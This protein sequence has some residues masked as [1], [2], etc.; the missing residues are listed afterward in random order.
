MSATGRS[1][2]LPLAILALAA[3]S[4]TLGGRVIEQTPAT[5]P[6]E[7]TTQPGQESR[8]PAAEISNDEGGPVVITGELAYTYPF[9]TEAVAEPIVILEDQ[10]GFVAR[11]RDFV[12]PV[13]SQVLGQI[14]SDFYT[15][16]FTYSLTLPLVPRGTLRDVDQDGGKD[17]GVMVF[18]VAY[19][20]NTWGDP[21]LERRDQGGGGWSSAYAST[22]VSDDRETYLEVYGGQLVIYAGDDQQGFPSGFGA[23]GL[24]FTED[25]PIVQLPQGWTVVNLD[26]EPFTFD[27]SRQP[28]IDLLEPES[29]ALDDFS[30]MSYAEGFDAMLEKFRTEYAFTEYKGLNWDAKSAEFRPRFEAAEA[31]GD[32]QAYWLALRD[33]LWSIPD[34]HVG[35]DLSGL[36]PLFIQQTAGGLGMAIM[37]LEDHRIL[38]DFVLEGGPA[39]QAGI[40]F[41]A[42]ILQI[43]GQPIGEAIAAAV[44]WSSPFSTQQNLRLQQLRYAIRFPAG[45]EV[46]LEFQNPGGRPQTTSL[47]VSDERDSFNFSSFFAGVTGLELPVEFRLLD[48]GYGYISVNDFFDNEVLT[49]QLWERAMQAL[50]QNNIPGLILDLRHNSG[51]NGFLARQMAAYF[52]NEELETGNTGYYDE[53]SGEFYF[54]PGDV[55]RM[56]PPRQE[57]QYDGPIV[58]LVGPACASACEF[59]GYS[60]TLQDRATVVGM[61]PT[62]G[63]GGSVQDFVM[64]EGIS[65]RFTI[66]RAVD[67]DGNIHIE[68]VGVVPDVRVPLTQENFLALYRDGQDIELQAALDAIG[69]PRGA[70]VIPQGPPRIA[71]RAESEDALAIQTPFLDNVAVES[72]QQELFQPGTQIYNIPMGESRDVLWVSGWCASQEQFD[73]NWE[74]IELAF[75]LNGEQVGLD[76]FAQLDSPAGADLCRFYYVLLTDWPVGEHVVSTEMRFATE[77]N[78]GIETQDYAPGSRFYE[79]HVYVTR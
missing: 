24:L 23:D 10:G 25:D 36:N 67:P 61:Y 69:K 2:S 51:G 73:Q 34:T 78:D 39:D 28:S 71:T 65:V 44:P 63:A 45:T 77:L 33:F 18:A 79:Y 46:E 40:V 3:L 55:D 76:R 50:N 54:D 53:S 4:C 43:N 68:G 15:S 48:Q 32:V 72:Y 8:F 42:E 21:Y 75:T 9:F 41:G 37:E 58:A 52:F 27:R 47:T 29:L 22:R 5:T 59:F 49:V 26:D 14:T 56:I 19:W 11:D 66:G 31:A 7:I 16:P 12:I 70:G 74:N 57:L 64:P 20:T 35:L 6:T 17:A 30:G 1:W 38:V 60:L 62:A 13:E